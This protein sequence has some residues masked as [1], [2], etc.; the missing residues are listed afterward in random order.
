MYLSV[1]PPAGKVRIAA[2]SRL[3]L[4]TIRVFAISKLGWIRQQQRKLREQERE[5]PR[6]YLDRESHY[7]WGRRYLLKFDEGKGHPS[8]QLEHSRIILRAP[9]GWQSEK[10]HLLFET[11]YRDQLKL[12]VPPL[13]K[14]WEAVLGVK[15]DRF[16]VRRMKTK[17]GSCNPRG[18][19]IRLNTDLAKKPRACLEYIVV[20]EMVHLL[21][22]THNSRFIA[23]MDQF[24]PKWQ[25]H[26]EILN[27]LP[28]RHETW[29]Y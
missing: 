9:S 29:T 4:D 13:I 6:E 26:R 3:G 16:F 28:V 5:S 12:A 25:F 11:W 21:E 18:R 15:V 17:W 14:K 22:P 20:H 7:L 23:L 1:L 10:K 24:L 2:P 19:T 27:E 8:L